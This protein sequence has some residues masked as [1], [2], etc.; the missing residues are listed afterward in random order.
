VPFPFERAGGQADRELPLSGPRPR[1]IDLLRE[2]DFELGVAR[3][4]P[5]ACEVEAPAVTIRLQPRVMQVLVAL[6]RADGGLVARE[7]LVES[8]WAGLIVSEDAVNRCVQQLRRLAERAPGAFVIETA[9][10]L[11]Y[12][13]IPDRPPG[14][15]GDA[16]TLGVLPFVSM[17]SDADLGHFS[18]G[19]SEELLNH[20][21]RL[22]GL[23]LAARTSSFAFK[24]Q[25]LDVRLVGERLGVANVLEGSVRR[26]GERLRITAQ[27]IDCADGFHLW[28]QAFDRRLGD[29]LEVQEDVARVVADA[30][31]TVLEPTAG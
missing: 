20:L 29:T 15:A 9:P 27:L 5:S 30:L 26:A 16:V 22:R 25:R 6:A 31:A 11:G 12:R 14:A 13:L 23:K 7:E 17:S 10:R 1:R 2:G 18:D 8:C 4:R 28:S 21:A 19:L 3:V 24:D